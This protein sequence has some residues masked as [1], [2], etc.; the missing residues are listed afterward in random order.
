VFR[1]FEIIGYKKSD[2]RERMAIYILVV[3][4]RLGNK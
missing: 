3:A 1:R 4:A 2:K